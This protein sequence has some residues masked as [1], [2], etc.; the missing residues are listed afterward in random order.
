MKSTENTYPLYIKNIAGILVTSGIAMIYNG[1][2]QDALVGGT[3][4]FIITIF[5]FFGKRLFFNSYLINLFVGLIAVLNAFIFHKI[6]LVID[7]SPAIIAVL[8]LHVPGMAFV[9]SMKEILKGNFLCGFYKSLD[10]LFLGSS[11]ASGSFLASQMLYFWGG[12]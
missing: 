2:F 6:G 7:V 10:A 1:T 3:G 12:I 11:L 5:N 4:G 8:L 9:H